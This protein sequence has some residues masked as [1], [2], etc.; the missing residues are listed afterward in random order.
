MTG[1]PV[2]HVPLGV[3][4]PAP[5]AVEPPELIARLPSGTLVLASFGYLAA[6]K[7]IDLVLK[8]LARLRSA[9][10]PFHYFLV[11]AP[12]SGFDVQAMIVG[13]DLQKLVT[14]TGYVEPPDFERYL[15][16]TDIGISLRAAPTGGEMS[17]ALLQMMAWGQP[18]LVSDVDAFAGLPAGTVLKVAQDDRE[19]GHLGTALERLLASPELRRQLGEQARRYVQENHSFDR[20]AGQLLDFIQACIAGSAPVSSPA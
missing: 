2:A 14:C 16:H 20:V 17:A 8:V 1:T 11:G 10:P 9:L 12:V 19:A 4:L 3:S 5:G 18:V 6:S 15:A 7:R 13:N